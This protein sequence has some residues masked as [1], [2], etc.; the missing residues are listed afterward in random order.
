MSA[1][2][3]RAQMRDGRSSWCHDCHAGAVKDWRV[4]KLEALSVREAEERKARRRKV[5]ADVARAKRVQERRRAQAAP[6]TLPSWARPPKPKP[7]APPKVTGRD[8]KRKPEPVEAEIRGL[9]VLELDAPQPHYVDG[10]LVS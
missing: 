2:P 1:F 9:T 5:R 4:R 3:R 10:E 7:D 8:K 6:P